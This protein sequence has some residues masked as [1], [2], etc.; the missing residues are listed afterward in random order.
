MIT[1]YVNEFIDSVDTI[2]RMVIVM[3]DI[4]GLTALAESMASAGLDR[5]SYEVYKDFGDCKYAVELACPKNRYNAIK[6]QLVK[7]K[8]LVKPLTSTGVIRLVTPIH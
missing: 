1:D 8:C 3:D 6:R 2:E 4:E 7:R 5:L